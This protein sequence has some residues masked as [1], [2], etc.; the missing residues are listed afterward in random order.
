MFAIA[1]VFWQLICGLEHVS[2]EPPETVLLEA[3][4]ANCEYVRAALESAL[5]EGMKEDIMFDKDKESS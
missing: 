1:E 4:R 3:R 5:T 2:G